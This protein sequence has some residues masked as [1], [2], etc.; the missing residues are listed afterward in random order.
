VEEKWNEAAPDFQ[1]AI[2]ISGNETK[3]V[4][5][6]VSPKTD[7]GKHLTFQGQLFSD[8]FFQLGSG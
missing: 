8:L 7:E 3:Y 5:R 1:M 2:H 4:R 6:S